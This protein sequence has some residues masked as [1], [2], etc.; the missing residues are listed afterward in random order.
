MKLVL[1][2]ALLVAWTGTLTA[3]QHMVQASGGG[4]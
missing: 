1:L 2:S 4:V 3:Q